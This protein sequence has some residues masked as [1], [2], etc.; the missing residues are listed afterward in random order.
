MLIVTRKPDQ[1]I[2][3][4]KNTWATNVWVTVLS[5]ERDRV[6]LHF[7]APHDVVISRDELIGEDLQKRIKEANLSDRELR[8]IQETLAKEG[9]RSPELDQVTSPAE[10]A[11]K[12]RFRAGGLILTRKIDQGVTIG[13][14]VGVR[15]LGVERDR[16]KLGIKAPKSVTILREELIARDIEEQRRAMEGQRRSFGERR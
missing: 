16:V 12:A 5:S 14:D 7:E 8:V 9:L 1:A 3:I 6:K 4:N 10:G 2:V 13:E 15:V 11:F